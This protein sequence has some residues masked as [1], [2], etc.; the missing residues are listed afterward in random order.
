VVVTDKPN[1]DGHATIVSWELSK[2]DGAGLN[3]VLAYEIFH[4]DSPEGEF[5][6]IGLM[7]KGMNT[8]T[9][10]GEG[11]KFKNGQ[12]NP[13]YI[14]TGID[15]YYKARAKTATGTSSDFSEVAVGQAKNNWLHTGKLN[16]G[17]AT[18]FF[19]LLVLYFI[20][21]ARK[22]KEL[23]VRPIPGIAAV[24]EAI[25][26]ATEMGRPILFVLGIGT[27]ADLATIAGFTILARVAKMT[28]EYQTK[29]LVPVRDP[30]V[31][32]V[33]QETVKSAYLEAGRP[34]AYD[35]KNIFF[36]TAMQFPFVASVCGIML[37]E[38]TATHFYMGKFY[39]ESLI[40]AETGTLTGAIQIS[41]TDEVP[42]LPFFVAATDYT[43]IG[44]ELYAASGYLSREPLL[45]GPLK[46]QDYTKAILM[47]LLGVGAIGV[48]FG[49]DLILNLLT[50][51]L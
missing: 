42:Q 39:A 28:A 19:I 10:R 1:D 3:N 26:R 41:G 14:G 12:P 33:A 47:V 11:E 24:D 8:F 27:A 13:R 31:L 43:L 29:V 37:R 30:V 6:K 50:T 35:E 34:D 48:T 2:D 36:V 32:A 40:L 45:L 46:A 25:G 38:K 49:W 44:E 5:Q 17:A 18:L 51:H 23:Y 7:G 21:A 16:I 20:L 15:Y 9:H 22:G 4:T